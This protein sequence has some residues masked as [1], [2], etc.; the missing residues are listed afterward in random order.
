MVHFDKHGLTPRIHGNTKRLPANTIPFTKTQSIIKFIEHFATVHALPLPGRLPGQYSD[1]KALLLP[2]YMSKRYVYR[3][4]CQACDEQKEMHV[5][6]RKFENL[7]SELLP[8]IAAMKPATDLCPIC[9]SNIITIFRSANLPDSEKSQNVKEASD[10]LMLV[11]QERKIYNEDCSQAAAELKLHPES[12]KVVHCSFDF[13][14]QIFFPSSPQ[15]VGP[16]YFLTPRKCQLFGICSEAKGEQI[17]YLIDEND[18]P[19]KGANCVVSLLHHYLESKTSIGQHLLLHAD[20]AVGQNKNNT[21]LQ[22][23]AWRVL[24]GR[25]PTI[26]ISFMIPGHTKFA[27][28]RFFGLVKKLYRRTSVSTLA[29]IED[30]VK[31]STTGNQNI[32]QPTVDCRTGKRYVTWYKWDEHLS[33][34]FRPLPGITKYHHFMLDVSALG[35][36]SVKEYAD[37]EEIAYKLTLEDELCGIHNMPPIITP[38][39]MSPERKVYLYEKIRPFI[40]SEEAAALTCPKPTSNQ[41][42]CIAQSTENSKKP[43]TRKCSHCHQSGHF[44]TAKGKITCPKLL[45]N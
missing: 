29:D 41:S 27:P 20:N 4:Y 3:Q 2:S 40:S 22:Y 6:R 26:K 30:V 28:D 16:L 31:K 21:V 33:T 18:S 14:Q 7:W 8:G 11:H 38:V 9:Q 13:A 5:S 34:F 10:H 15:Q 36:V 32:P 1:E 42:E 44:K 19:G 12:P 25:N 17:Q 23:L 39:G 35:S 45:Q 24:N 43:K 37:A